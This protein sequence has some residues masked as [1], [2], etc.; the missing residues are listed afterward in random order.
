MAGLYIHIPFCRR[1]CT[2]C[3]FFSIE[4]D[5]ATVQGYAAL[6]ISHLER[7]AQTDWPNSIETIY[8]GGGTPSLLSTAS[9]AAILTAVDQHFKIANDAEISLEANPGTVSLDSLTG[10]RS[11]GINRL[12]LG[13]QSCEEHQLRKLGRLHTSAEGDD[14]IRWARQAGFDNISID[15]MFSLPGQTHADLQKELCYF[16]ELGAEHLSCYGLTAEADTP[17]HQQIASG[18]LSL[19]A[20]DFYS[21]AFMHIHERLAS[22]GYAHYEIANYAQ[23]GLEC[24]H[25][26]NYWK[27]G[28][29]L[30]VGAGAHSFRDHRWGSRW[31][32]PT[33]VNIYQRAL[34]NKQEPMTCLETFDAASAL[35]ETVYL[36]LRTRRGITDAELQQRFDT[37]LQDA[38][39]EAITA[40]AGWLYNEDGR[41]SLTPS[42]WLLFDRLILPFL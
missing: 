5:D 27:R 23:P 24:R 20:D 12:S 3:D 42:G 30:G 28:A 10:Y 8:F 36:A 4:A 33:D 34:H 22:A 17:L 13:L 1:K 25:N 29:C 6:L 19:P 35:R 14:A 39:P 26:L 7:A 2:Y 16:L 31:E 11:V 37:T 9:V 40:S 32:V 41:W 15:L 21:D 38:F 18:K